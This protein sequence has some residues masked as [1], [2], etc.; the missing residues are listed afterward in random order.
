MNI[1]QVSIRS[2]LKI[3]DKHIAF[4]GSGLSNFY[5]CT[6]NFHGNTFK[7]S[8]QLFMYLK[9]RHFKDEDIAQ[10]IL[11]AKTP[12]DAKFLGR[13]VRGFDEVE[14]AKERCTY[15]E[16][17]LFHKFRQNKSL[18]DFL[19]SPEFDGKHFVEGS[20]TDTIWGVGIHYTNPEI[21]NPQ[22]W[23]GQN[24]L[25]KALDITRGLVFSEI[26]FKQS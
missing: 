7:S 19:R 16:V 20:P 21:D 15:M 13:K 4:Y 8:E 5:P 24:L 14:W 18:A 1:E 3:Y 10:K 6:I 17:A 2:G 23:K 25:G 26:M 11:L 22:N 9:A 12:R